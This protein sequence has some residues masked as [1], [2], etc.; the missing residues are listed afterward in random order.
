MGVPA[1]KCLPA[2]F[3]VAS[4]FALSVLAQMTVI[5]RQKP[6]V[7]VMEVVPEEAEQ[8]ENKQSEV[9]D[10]MGRVRMA[11]PMLRTIT[12]VMGWTAILSNSIYGL[13]A[14]RFMGFQQAQLSATYSMAAVMMVATQVAFPRLVAKVG[15]HRACTLGILAAGAGIGGQSLVRFQ[16]LHS[17]LYMMNRAGAAI[18]D[19]STATLVASSSGSKEDRSRNLALLTSTRAA[20]R[21]ITPLLSSK[22]FELSCKSSRFPGALPFVTAACFA[23]AVAPLPTL[24]L[25]AEQKKENSPKAPL[26]RRILESPKVNLLWNLLGSDPLSSSNHKAW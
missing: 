16:P 18:A 11:Q 9:E 13:F 6:S 26:Y 10:Q 4:V 19:T 20:A 14:P 1:D 24:L 2:V 15:A 3:V 23:M 5:E 8:L 12:I 21:I 7:S 25:K 17:T 22:M